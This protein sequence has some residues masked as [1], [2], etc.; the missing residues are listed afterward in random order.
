MLLLTEGRDMLDN[1]SVIQSYEI[2]WGEIYE[3]S[4][5]R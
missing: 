1:L 5:F 4:M 2:K 3:I